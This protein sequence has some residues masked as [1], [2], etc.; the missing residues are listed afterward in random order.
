[1]LLGRNPPCLLAGL[2]L[3]SACCLPTALHAQ[4]ATVPRVT[5]GDVDFDYDELG[6]YPE[7]VLRMGVEFTFDDNPDPA[8]LNEKW[9]DRVKVT[10]WIMFTNE[11]AEGEQPKFFAYQSAAHLVSVEADEDTTIYFYLP[12]EIVDRDN[13]QSDP[14]G[15]LVEFEV[16]GEKVTRPE[17]DAFRIQ[18]S[19]VSVEQFKSNIEPELD[20]TA[21]L[22]MNQHQFDPSRTIPAHRESP[23][24]YEPAEE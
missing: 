5:V 21:G 11:D 18:S 16:D 10:V 14:F 13:L 2:F 6:L 23:T 20:K 15:Y 8:A 12:Y 19:R 9:I 24:F 7:E 17:G 1:M 4:Q 22:F 3:V